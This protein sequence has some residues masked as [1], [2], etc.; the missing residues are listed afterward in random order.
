LNVHPETN[1]IWIT[2]NNSD[3]L[4]QFKQGAERFVAYPSPTKVTFL[5]DIVFS[6]DGKVCSSQSNLPVYAIEGGRPSFIC[7]DPKGVEKDL[8][9]IR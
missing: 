3:R 9:Q 6:R 7:L 2:S 1:D 4:F 8:Q 5:R